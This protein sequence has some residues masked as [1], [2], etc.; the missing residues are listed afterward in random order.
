MCTVYTVVGGV[1]PVHVVGEEAEYGSTAK[2]D[3]IY[4]IIEH[5]CNGMRRLELFGTDRNLRRGC[6]ICVLLLC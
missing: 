5:F 1:V 3:G 2:P 6:K 4:D